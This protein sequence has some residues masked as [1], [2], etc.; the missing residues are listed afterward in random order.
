MSKAKS[1]FRH[2]QIV[3]NEDMALIAMKYRIDRNSPQE[4]FQLYAVIQLLEQHLQENKLLDI[5][6][7]MEREDPGSG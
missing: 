7:Q 4:I 6:V 1:S 5:K 2:P 3:N